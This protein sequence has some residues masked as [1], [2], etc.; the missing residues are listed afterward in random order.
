VLA[1]LMPRLPSPELVLVIGT[2]ALMIVVAIAAM[3]IPARGIEDQ[4]DARAQ[5]RVV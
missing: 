5:T 4:P 2:A 3:Y 1:S